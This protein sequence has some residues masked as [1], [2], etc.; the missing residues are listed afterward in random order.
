VNVFRETL[1]RAF[2]PYADLTAIQLD[3]LE[4][5]FRLLEAWNRKVNLM[6]FRSIQELIELHYCESMYLATRL[7][8]GSLRI[9]DLGSGA[10]FPGIPITILR[11]DCE[12]TLIESHRRKAV[13]LREATRGL[14]HCRVIAERAA[15]VHEKFDW[16]VSRA[17]SPSDVISLGLSQH[18]ALL[19]TYSAS[20]G[21]CSGW[22]ISKTPWGH[23]RVVAMFHV[24]Q[25][26]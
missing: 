6:R 15:D 16:V 18:I 13:F 23:G 17:V 21:W 4:A 25:S 1:S 10:G 8:E 5:H 24:E 2:S 12:V 3:Q 7:P 22:S 9:A 14:G 26:E 20:I 11:T 19:G